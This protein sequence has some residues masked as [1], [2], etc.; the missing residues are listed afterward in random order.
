MSHGTSAKRMTDVHAALRR[1]LRLS[2]NRSD[3]RSR[4]A[5]TAWRPKSRAGA[6]RSRPRA[7][8]AGRAQREPLWG[9][10][11]PARTCQAIMVPCPL[12]RCAKASLWKCPLHAMCGSMLILL[13]FSEIAH[14]GA[15][16]HIAPRFRY[17]LV[18]PT[19]DRAAMCGFY[20]AIARSSVRRFVGRL[21][22]FLCGPSLNCDPKKSDQALWRQVRRRFIAVEMP[23]LWW[24]HARHASPDRAKLGRRAAAGCADSLQ[25]GSRNARDRRLSVGRGNVE[26][27][28]SKRLLD[29]KTNWSIY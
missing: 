4:E 9:C 10:G 18:S 17:C 24:P 1:D 11:G 27:C 22:P 15:K 13:G 12:H 6:D 14:C 28:D 2:R 25:I 26:C 19:F 8:G 29:L 21:P 7:G 3:L 16:M 23:V 5:M 20:L